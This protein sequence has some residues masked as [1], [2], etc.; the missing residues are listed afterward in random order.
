MERIRTAVAGPPCSAGT[1]SGDRRRH[2]R[3]AHRVGAGRRCAGR[4]AWH[5]GRHR[6]GAG[7]AA[8]GTA[9]DD[10]EAGRAA[11]LDRAGPDRT[12]GRSF[13][14]NVRTRDWV[15][16]RGARRWRTPSST[17]SCA[18]YYLDRDK[19]DDSESEAWAIGGSVGFK[20]GYFRERF[21]FGATGYTS[22]PLHAPGGQGRHP[23][24]EARP[25]GLHRARRDLRRVAAQRRTCA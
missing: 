13:G 18:R 23:A 20:T 3:R 7:G 11:D 10:A 17:C 25:G 19:Y 24:A 4:V 6:R 2:S 8:H 9:P 15:R 12:L 5:D 16:E 22:Q 1:R 21:A 14:P